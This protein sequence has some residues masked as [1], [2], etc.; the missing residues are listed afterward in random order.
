[1]PVETVSVTPRIQTVTFLSG[2]QIT[3]EK[4][5]VQVVVRGVV[6]PSGP[7][8]ESAEGV[9]EWAAQVFTLADPQQEF[10]LDFA[11]REGSVLVYL[12]GLLE[13][14]WALSDTTLTLDESGLE[15]DTLT[16]RY[17]KEI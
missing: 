14:F 6:G 10:T 17:Q 11:P 12:N 7:P 4:Q 15:G 16:V 3:I 5:N 2:Q 1:M 13:R 8:G 9:Y